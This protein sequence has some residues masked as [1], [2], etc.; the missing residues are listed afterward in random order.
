MVWS[1]GNYTKGN[2]ATGGWTG[3]ASLGIGIEAGRHDTQDNDFATGIDQCLNKDGSNAATGNLNLGGFIPT[4]LAAGTAAAPALCAGGDVNTGVFGPAADTWAVSTN[5]S[6]RIRITNNGSLLKGVTS[7]RNNFFQ[8]WSAIDQIEYAD[9]TA[10]GAIASRLFTKIHNANSIDAGYFA[11]AK[12]RGTTTGSVTVVQ[13]NDQLGGISFQGAD[14]ANFIEGARIQAFVDGTPGVT[15]MPTRLVFSTTTDGAGSTSE[16][17]RITS[18]GII[19]GAADALIELNRANATPATSGGCQRFQIDGTNHVAIA[20]SASE[21]C[22][23]YTG[24]GTLGERIRFGASNF[25]VFNLGSGAGTNTM[26]YNSSTGAWTYDV[27]SLRYKKNIIDSSYGLEAVLRLRSTQFNYNDDNRPDVGF[28]AEELAEIIPELAPLDSG[29]T[30]ISVS[31]DRLTSVLCK[32]I[33]ELNAKVDAL[34]ARVAELE[35]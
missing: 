26:K 3:D 31:Y 32:A 15:D 34:E 20:T 22:S 24:V 14:G 7:E 19:R 27:S 25:A 6:E 16:R 1:G 8:S 13:N 18:A 30:P 21:T 5:G 2:N 33:Q 12:T 28:I 23:I 9:A 35:A 11:L 29:G 10:G 4:N 17:M